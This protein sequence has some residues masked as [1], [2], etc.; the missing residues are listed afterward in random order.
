MY[1]DLMDEKLLSNNNIKQILAI[2]PPE[3][4]SKPEY[5][6]SLADKIPLILDADSSQQTVLIEA[7]QHNFVIQGPPGTGKSQTIANLIAASIAQGKS[8]LFVAEK[9][10][11]LQ[12]VSSRL[13]QAGLGDFCLELHNHKTQKTE[14]HANLATRLSSEYPP[15]QLNLKSL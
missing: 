7:L 13:Q 3:Q 15:V 6:E 8:V 4:T 1:K 12:V 11:A 14:L 5:N 9:K 10:A 2:S